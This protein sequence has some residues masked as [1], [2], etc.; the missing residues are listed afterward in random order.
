M[1]FG[2]AALVAGLQLVNIMRL[3]ETLRQV[4]GRLWGGYGYG[5]GYGGCE[6]G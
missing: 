6:G 4:R 3:R 2:A 5:Y 1:A